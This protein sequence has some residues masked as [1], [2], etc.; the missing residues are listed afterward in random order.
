MD[1]P[2]LYFMSLLFRQPAASPPRD[3]LLAELTRTLGRVKDL[4]ADRKKGISTF[5]LLDHV[6]GGKG[7]MPTS[8]MM[9]ACAP[10]REPLADGMA[11][12]QFW[13][14]KDGA[15]LLDSCPFHVLIGDFMMTRALPPVERGNIL[16]GWLEAALAL[17]PGC[18]AV[19]FHPSAKLLTPGQLRANYLPGGRRFLYGAVNARFF[20]IANT[21]G[22]CVVDTLGLHAFGLPDMQ[23]HYHGLNTDD[24][25]RHAWD[26][27]FYQFENDAP[28]ESGHTIAGLNPEE[29]WRCQH[30]KSLIGPEREV[31]D[32]AAGAHAAGRRE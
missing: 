5:A 4:G 20:N 9:E 12:Q 25:V 17:F 15:A 18:E 23:Y 3:A 22:D 14:V 1:A 11:R 8:V 13:D 6:A 16:N 27:A 26:T 10:I 2:P 19:F 29:K 24:V 7:G 32:V 28:I 21:P 30:E 31:L